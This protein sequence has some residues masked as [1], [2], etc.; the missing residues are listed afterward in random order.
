MAGEMTPA[1]NPL[2]RPAEATHGEGLGTIVLMTLM[3]FIDALN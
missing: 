2:P 1:S 3:V